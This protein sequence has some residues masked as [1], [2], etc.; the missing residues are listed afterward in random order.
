MN[1]IKNRDGRK[2]ARCDAGLL[3][4][5]FLAASALAGCSALTHKDLMPE[6]PAGAVRTGPLFD[7]TVSAHS[8]MIP[9]FIEGGQALPSG[10]LTLRLKNYVDNDTLGKG[11]SES[12]ANSSLFT[13]VAPKNAD[14][15]LDVWVEEAKNYTPTMGIGHFTADFSSIWRLTRVRDGKV[16]VCDYV[17]GQGIIKS[18]MRPMQRSLF[19]GLQDMI[20]NGLLILSDASKEHAAASAI[21]RIRPSMGAAVPEGLTQWSDNVKNHWPKLRMGLTLEEV[22]RVIGPVKT[23]GALVRYYSQGYTQEFDTGLYTVVFLNGKLSRWELR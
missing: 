14:Y 7:G 3:L 5:L 6:Q 18:G 10:R 20:Q 19:A 12:V 8:M 21:A 16:L 22:E 11:L 4:I 13:R 17:K 2:P 1:A 23:S 15:V 9:E